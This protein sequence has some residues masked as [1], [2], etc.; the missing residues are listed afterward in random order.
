MNPFPF[1]T[2]VPSWLYSVRSG[3]RAGVFAVAL[4]V[5]SSCASAP[6]STAEIAEFSQAW[7]TAGAGERGYLVRID[8]VR[9]H[10][11]GKEQAEVLEFLGSPDSDEGRAFVYRLGWTPEG[12]N[13]YLK[14]SFDAE[15][16]VDGVYGDR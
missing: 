7:K 9:E 10:L 16:R 1:V 14:V 4:A 13:W 12:R 5:L 3:A 8:L 11:A 15:G 6:P 2:F